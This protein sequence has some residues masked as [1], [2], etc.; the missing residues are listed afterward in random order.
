MAAGLVHLTFPINLRGTSVPLAAERDRLFG[1]N[2]DYVA[3]GITRRVPLTEGRDGEMGTNIVSPNVKY[4]PLEF[5]VFIKRGNL[6]LGNIPIITN[7]LITVYM[8]NLFNISTC[9]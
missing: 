2:A 3:V 7:F 5:M 9:F 8:T 4:D 6:I 1:C